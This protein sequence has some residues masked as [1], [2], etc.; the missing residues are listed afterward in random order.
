MSDNKK[1]I[2]LKKTIPFVL[3]LIFLCVILVS[4]LYNLIK[5]VIKPSNVF[6]VEERKDL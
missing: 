4:F 2:N 5:L 1:K 3:S 6:S